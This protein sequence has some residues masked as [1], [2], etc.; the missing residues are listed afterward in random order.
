MIDDPVPSIEYTGWSHIVEALGLTNISTTDPLV[1][2]QS[3]TTE[4]ANNVSNLSITNK[5]GGVG[6]FFTPHSPYINLSEQRL[7]PAEP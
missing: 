2:P 3:L 7:I 1:F 5:Y 6:G 4:L